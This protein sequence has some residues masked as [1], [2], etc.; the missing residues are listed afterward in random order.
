MARSMSYAF[1]LLSLL[2]PYCGQVVKIG[3][4]TKHQGVLSSEIKCHIDYSPE[5][6]ISTAV[7]EK[8]DFGCT[9]S[10]G[11]YLEISCILP[12]QT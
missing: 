11:L 1:L 6:I 8:V 2:L 4:F 12:G 7:G 5:N 10:K 9:Y 3:N